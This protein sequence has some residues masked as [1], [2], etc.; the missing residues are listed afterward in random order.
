MKSL[1]IILR[2]LFIIGNIFFLILMVMAAFSDRIS[3]DKSLLMAYLG[4]GF[5]VFFVLNCF[6]AIYWLFSKDWK[7]FMVSLVVFL[8]CLGPVSRYFPYHRKTD[9][10]PQ[11]NVIKV[12]TY[13]VMNFAGKSH[14]AESPNHIIEYIAHSGADIVCLQEYT[15]S[16]SGKQL[17]SKDVF[18]ALD[19][20]PY[21]TVVQFRKT[22]Y[23]IS[24]NAIFSKFPIK[25]TRRIKY[26]TIAN[27][28]VL[29]EL[30]INGKKMVVINNH[31]ESFKLTQKDRTQYS[32]LIKSFDTELL[33][34]IRGTFEQKLGPAFRL[35]AQQAHVVADEINKADADY[36]LVCGDFNDTPLSYAH[37]VIQG[38]LTDAFVASGRGLGTTYNQNLFLFRIDNILHSSNITPY[39]CTIDHV[40]YSDHYPMWCYL[41]LD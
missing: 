7:L 6:Y 34:E 3:P 13:N 17:T 37:R 29:H 4:L 31:L 18:K 15:V 32:S 41:Q 19:M 22:S 28:S 39:N 27:G 5:P 8:I 11:E 1:R 12:L 23:G 20:Y 2:F 36:I 24:G 30:D 9:P 40:K 26:E 38:N 25:K 14:T 21:R 35:R 16:N 33:N 10:V